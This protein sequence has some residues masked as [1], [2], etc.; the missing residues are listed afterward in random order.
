MCVYIYVFVYVCVCVRVA[1]VVDDTILSQEAIGKAPFCVCM[2]VYVFV[3]ICVC[4]AGDVDDTILSQEAIGKAPLYVCVYIWLVLSIC[5]PLSYTCINM[6]L[7]EYIHTYRTTQSTYRAHGK[8]PLYVV[9]IA[10]FE[11]FIPHMH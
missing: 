9:Y 5:Y 4:V 3:Y 2:C 6:G 10:S 8:P 1:G 7:H 11:Y